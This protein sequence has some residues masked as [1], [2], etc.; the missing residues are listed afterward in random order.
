MTSSHEGRG[1]SIPPEVERW[2]AR[3]LFAH[4]PANIL[5][6]DREFRVVTSNRSFRETFG[7]TEG[8]RCFEVC[9]RRSERCE[10][11]LAALTFEDGRVRFSEEEGVDRRGRP[12][13]FVV[14]VAPVHDDGRGIPYV[15]TMSHDV[16]RS[17]TLEQQYD[18]L[19]E[20][21]PC[22]LAVID[23]EFQV[24]RAN[25]RFRSRFGDVHGKPC[26]RTYMGRE[27]PCEDCPALRT[28]EDGRPY[29]AKQEGRDPSGGKRF[30]LVSTTPLSRGD[31][32]FRYV[33][34]MAVDITE[35]QR[36]AEELIREGRFRYNMMENAID[37]LLSADASGR[38]NMFNKAAEA[39]F[40]ADRTG[41]VGTAEVWSF[42]P[43]A[44]R[45]AVEEG[46]SALLIP[47]TSIRNA[48][49]EEIP[50]RFSGTTLFEG[51]RHIGVAAFFQDLR[52]YKRLER[53]KL[54]NERL[55]TVGQ[56]V[57]QMAHAIKN[58]LTGLQGGLYV[59]KAGQ[60]DTMDARTRQG[61]EMLERNVGRI[62]EMV[63]GFLDFTRRHEPRPRSVDP[64]GIAEEVVR[65]FHD[66]AEGEGIRLRFRRPEDAIRARLDPEDLRVCLENLVSNALDACRAS[67]KSAPRVEMKVAVRGSRVVITVRDNG[68]G[69]EEAVRKRLFTSFFSTKGEKGT[70]LGLLV[71]R[72]LV[73]E[74]GGTIEVDSTPG[75]GSEFRILLPREGSASSENAGD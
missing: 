28:F 21:V 27:T 75:E 59:V 33:I 50:V 64:A 69:M 9:K 17:R 13:Y 52:E 49:G 4:V 55:A 74:A 57:A 61:W 37:A 34:E 45:R 20:R 18:M 24:V 15:I 3:E 44:F 66:T 38:I 56:T 6:V 12:A 54:E 7:P 47:E 16:T 19:F 26:Y 25:E 41:L 14:H 35:N 23:R 60:K 53:E 40:G 70:G 73:H 39:L 65:L 8:R 11:C 29:T 62:S 67:P 46:R 30:Y 31:G 1:E 32:A 71:T 68:C 63:K 36:L 42:V 48:A 5:V 58:I 22:F 72:K 2:L 51:G 43:G 10:E